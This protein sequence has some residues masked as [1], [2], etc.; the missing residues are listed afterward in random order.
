MNHGDSVHLH[1]R[2]STSFGPL[3]TTPTASTLPQI[4]EPLFP[5]KVLLPY[6]PTPNTT[7]HFG[8]NNIPGSPY[9]CNVAHKPYSNDTSSRPCLL[10]S[11]A[12]RGIVRLADASQWA[13]SRGND[14][15]TQWAGPQHTSTRPHDSFQVA[16]WVL[17]I[18]PPPQYAVPSNQSPCSR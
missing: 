17:P 3:V 14:A 6:Q 2:S 15:T 11:E 9:F 13:S 5:H 10:T 8:C 16:L 1:A 12:A 4:T 7:P 18:P